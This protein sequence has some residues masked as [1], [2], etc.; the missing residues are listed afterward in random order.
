MISIFA[1]AFK[2]CRQA[3]N[4]SIVSIAEGFG[5]AFWA[6]RI[7]AFSFIQVNIGDSI[8][9]LET[10]VLQSMACQSKTFFSVIR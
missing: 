7:L 1:Q 6:D 3:M 10:P 5:L 8:V 9:S 4:G 2:I